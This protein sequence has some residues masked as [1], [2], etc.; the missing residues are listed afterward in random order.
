MKIF[1]ILYTYY[2]STPY[3]FVLTLKIHLKLVFRSRKAPKLKLKSI[4][5]FI[6]KIIIFYV[7]YYILILN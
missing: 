2:L 4:F 6:F 5:I 7:N 1:M 3:T